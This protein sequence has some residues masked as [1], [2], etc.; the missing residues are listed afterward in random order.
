MLLDA[1]VV[2]EAGDVGATLR[3]VRGYKP[4]VLVLDL[5][6]RAGRASRRSRGSSRHRPARGS[7]S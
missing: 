4:S 5:N 2:A 7:S 1:E 6:I 3:K